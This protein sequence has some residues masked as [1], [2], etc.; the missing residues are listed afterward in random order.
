[1]PVL[2][3]GRRSRPH[4]T[5]T[6]YRRKLP[7]WQPGEAA[8]FLTWRLHGSSPDSWLVR[9]DAPNAGKDFVLADRALDRVDRGPLWL[10][11]PRIAKIVVDSFFCGD[12]QL[13]QY[14]LHAY[15]V[16]ANHVHLLLSP[17]V[18]LARITRSIKGSTARRANEI[19]GRTGE[20]FWRRESYDHWVRSPAEFRKIVRYIEWNPVKAGLVKDPQEYPWSSARWRALDESGMREEAF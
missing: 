3:R 19:L 15:V 1:M 10:K 17:K 14:V 16:M 4:Y 9:P 11:D 2:G 13:E 8:I 12:E 18:Q 6:Y 5:M 20:L 7:P